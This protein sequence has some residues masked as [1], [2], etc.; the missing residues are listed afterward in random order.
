VPN[1]SLKLLTW[2]ILH[3]GGTARRPDIVL[4]LLAHA[5]DVIVL[6]EFRGTQGGQIAA[7]LAD[8]GFLHQATTPTTGR[9]NGI[10]IASKEAVVPRGEVSPP[11]WAVGRF[12]D[13]ILP[14]RGLGVTGVHIPDDSRPGDK[15][16]FWQFL[17]ALGRTR[18]DERWVVLGDLNSGRPGIDEDGRTLGGAH[19]LGQFATLGYRDAWRDKNPDSL[20]RSWYSHA[21]TG[22]RID[23]AF[24]SPGLS[25]M[26]QTASFSHVEREQRMSDHSVLVVELGGLERRAE[27]KNTPFGGLWAHSESDERA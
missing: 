6:T 19:L 22:F 11:S 25:D 2:N 15:A 16:E 21:G 14:E 27:P 17:I 7:A 10:L 26:V 8:H 5:P 20:E 13:V 18:L 23:A 1:A 9:A 12:L 3:G 24:V 4:A